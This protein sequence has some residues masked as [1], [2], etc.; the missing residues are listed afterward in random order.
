MANLPSEA[1]LRDLAGRLGPRGFSRDPAD[2]APWLTDWRGRWRGR[3]AALVSPADT[4]EVQ[5]IVGRCAA[6]GV[7]IVPQGGNSSMVGG[8]TPDEGGAAL[9]LSLRRMKA[10]R[11]LSPEDNALVAEAGAILADVHAAAEGIGRRFPLTLG[12]KGSATV[13]G[14][15]STN[16]GG[17]QVLRFG[18]MRSLVLGLEAVLPDGSVLEGLSALRKDNRGYDLKQ[19]LIGAEGTLGVVTAASLRLV[20]AIGSRAVAW[21]GLDSPVA[22][23]GLLRRL[24]DRLGDSVESFELVPKAA[25]SLVLRHI[26]G[27]RAP[28]GEDHAWNVL[29]ETVA[30]QGAPEAGPALESA[31][32]GAIGAGLAADATLAASEA[33]AEAL[34][35][36]RDSIS[37]AERHAGAAAKHD[38][39]VPVSA[40]PRFVE[41][42]AAAVE[43][44]FP[45]TTVIAFGHLGDG[46]VHFNVQAPAGADGA[47]WL[48]SAAPHVSA[49]VYA[50]T[51]AAGGSISAEHGI[52]QMKREA[53]AAS[54][55][56]VQLAVQRAIKQAL[57]PNG[58]MNPG[59]LLPG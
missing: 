37:E 6:E 50:E 17:T 12:A 29:V 19:L 10:I 25:L 15:V 46:N 3:A 41:T 8:A 33:Q 4:A 48:D 42:I 52:G 24:E 36:L 49:F 16:A 55:S 20:P 14:L 47:A 43:R 22:A 38:I 18:P 45:G 27:A 23:L 53:L 21:V 59:N 31:L 57:D 13:G 26:P 58:I 11:R 44:R 9:L 7:A 28:L 32:A 30:P 2:M 56:T 39:S 1:M 54:T 35:R 34:W 51:Q 5:A 40:M